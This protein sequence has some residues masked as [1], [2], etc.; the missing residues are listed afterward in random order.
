MLINRLSDP[1][2]A[3]LKT[4]GQTDRRSRSW[5]LVPI[6]SGDRVI[7]LLSAQS[8][9]PCRYTDVDVALLQAVA[10]R[11]ARAVERLRP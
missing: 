1:T 7:A 4:F 6:R 8:Y 5:M 11:S 9:T 10:S 3:P 2:N